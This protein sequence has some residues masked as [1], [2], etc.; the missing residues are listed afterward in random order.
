LEDLMTASA[1]N[2][3]QLQAAMTAIP[4]CALDELGRREQRDRYARLANAVTRLTRRGEVIEIE[5]GEDLDRAALAQAL[6]VERECC[7]FFVFDFDAPSGRLRMT[8]DAPEH[9]PALDAVAHALESAQA[10][11]RPSQPERSAGSGSPSAI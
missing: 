7:P 4:S 8:V 10:A 9:A 11:G 5:F 2:S 1:P 6:A 3:G